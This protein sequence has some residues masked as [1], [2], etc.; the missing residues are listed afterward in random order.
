MCKLILRSGLIYFMLLTFGCKVKTS[1]KDNPDVEQTNQPMKETTV[2][3]STGQQ[4]VSNVPEI[5]MNGIAWNENMIIEF[6]KIYR[7]KP[8]PGNYWY[9]T[10]S[11]LWGIWG[12]D[13]VGFIYSG[14]QYGI[15]TRNSSNGN[16]GVIIN[17]R[18]LPVSEVITWQ[19]ITGGSAVPG[20]YWLDS[21]GNL[22][23]EGS[24]YA[25]LNLYVVAAQNSYGGNRGNGGQD[26]FWSSRFSAGNY[27][28]GSGSGYI[29]VPG[30]GPVGFGN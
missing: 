5:I 7:V 19:Q 28:A 21:Q 14:H 13:A 9:D 1:I 12:G 6:E 16:S 29:S 3:A 2:P 4:T 24:P 8:L 27:D 26:G 11:G 15:L 23:Y 18:E 30:Y 17:G 22:G 20:R 25:V 10:K